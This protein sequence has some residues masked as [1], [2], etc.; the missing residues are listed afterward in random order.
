MKIKELKCSFTNYPSA[1]CQNK[2]S[3]NLTQGDIIKATVNGKL[4]TL[5]LKTKKYSTPIFHQ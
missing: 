3:M 5:F 1:Q 2:E 4:L